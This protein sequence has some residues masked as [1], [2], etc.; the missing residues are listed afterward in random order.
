[1]VKQDIPKHLIYTSVRKSDCPMHDEIEIVKMQKGHK[2]EGKKNIDDNQ[3]EYYLR[4]EMR[5]IEKELG[6]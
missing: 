4:E 5:V 1:M 6:R 3:R 2:R